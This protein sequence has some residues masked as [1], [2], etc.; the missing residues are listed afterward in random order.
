MFACRPGYHG[1][2]A[3]I[4]H[5]ALVILGEVG[6]L[7][8]DGTENHAIV[9]F[10]PALTRPTGNV[11]PLYRVNLAPRITIAQLVLLFDNHMC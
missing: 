10:C 7:V 9:N 11:C 6:V 3:I 5:A 2:N 8:Y 1:N 4:E